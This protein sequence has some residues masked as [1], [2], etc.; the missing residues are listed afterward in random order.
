MGKDT[1]QTGSLA[2]RLRTRLLERIASGELVPGQLVDEGEPLPV[3][4]PTVAGYEVLEQAATGGMG[5]VFAAIAQA[6]GRRVA[7]KL[8]R[9]DRRGVSAAERILREVHALSA[10]EHPGIVA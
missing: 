4:L 9:P 7:L 8:V 10:V 1:T 3:A 2:R 6:T 5:V